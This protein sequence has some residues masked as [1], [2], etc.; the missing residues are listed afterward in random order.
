MCGSRDF[1]QKLF[2]QHWNFVRSH[3]SQT[4]LIPFD[5][6]DSHHDVLAD[7]DFLIQFSRQN[8]HGH[9]PYLLRDSEGT[10]TIL[11][12]P[13]TFKGGRL[14]RNVSIEGK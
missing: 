14:S 13:R 1:G 8:E 2:T 3:N 12:K 9:T 10:G 5:P 7:A 4:D 6:D 11:G